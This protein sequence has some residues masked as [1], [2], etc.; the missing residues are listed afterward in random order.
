MS[1]PEQEDAA[2]EAPEAGGS[3]ETP[4]LKGRRS[5]SRA[6]REL[7]EDELSHGAVQKIMLDELDRL[8]AEN[9][10][11]KKIVD[12]YYAA[13]KQVAVLTEKQKKS[14]SSEIIYGGLMTVGSAALGYAPTA[15]ANGSLDG[16]ILIFGFI[17]VGSGIASKVVTK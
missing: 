15:G 8:D 3:S 14:N 6:R 1:E 11:L 7:T 10:D 13:D 5:F 4:R 16:I 17:L 12:Q 9:G 2:D